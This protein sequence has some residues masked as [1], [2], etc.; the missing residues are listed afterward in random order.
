LM[1]FRARECYRRYYAGHAFELRQIANSPISRM[2]AVLSPSTR[3]IADSLE[4]AE[5]IA[6]NPDIL[7]RRRKYQR[8]NARQRF[9][10]PHRL[11][12]IQIDDSFTALLTRDPGAFMAAV[13]KSHNGRGFLR[14]EW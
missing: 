14:I 12:A 7:P 8:A 6:A 10:I 5:R 9:R 4:M 3:V 11:A 2:I 13:A 1:D